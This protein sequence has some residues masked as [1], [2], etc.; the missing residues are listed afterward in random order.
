MAAEVEGHTVNTITSN[1]F[2]KYILYFTIHHGGNS[3]GRNVLHY[4]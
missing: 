4:A 3:L 2:N 1:T